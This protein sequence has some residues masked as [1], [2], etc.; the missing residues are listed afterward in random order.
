MDSNSD[1]VINLPA[2]SRQTVSLWIRGVGERGLILDLVLSPR[3]HSVH[4][5]GKSSGARDALVFR[6]KGQDKRVHTRI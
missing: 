1:D 2:S 5:G 3:Y 4:D 6:E